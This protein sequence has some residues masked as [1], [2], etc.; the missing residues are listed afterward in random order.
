MAD[1]FT[2]TAHDAYIDT[3]ANVNGGQLR[4]Y[5][6]GRYVGTFAEMYGASAVALSQIGSRTVAHVSVHGDGHEL[7]AAL[8][9]GS[10]LANVRGYGSARPSMGESVSLQ[11][12][13]YRNTTVINVNGSY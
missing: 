13:G 6:N 7:G 2:A 8:S 3:Y 10:H 11:Q 5:Q 1:G 12:H 9:N 4:V